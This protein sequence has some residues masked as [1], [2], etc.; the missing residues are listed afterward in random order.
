MRTCHWSWTRT[1]VWLGIIS[2]ASVV[3]HACTIFVLT[4]SGKALF[5]NNE[6][7]SD[8]NTRIWFV[9]AGE[10]FFGCAYVGFDNGWAQGGL[11]A[12]GL[13]FDWVAGF[14]EKWERDP[15]LKELRGQP[16]PAHARNLPD[17]R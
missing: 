17:G 10:G 14:S 11:N 7:W 9:P 3:I 12:E 8:P 13:A 16:E 4:E 5:F 6:D 15:K 2:T 1:A